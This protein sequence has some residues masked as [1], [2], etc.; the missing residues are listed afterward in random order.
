MATAAI[1]VSDGL[2]A[3]VAHLC[4]ASKVAARLDAASVP[5]SPAA[6]A[7]IDAE[8]ALIETALTGGDDYELAF[9]L[10]P[11]RRAAAS[12]LPTPVSLIG[13]IEAGE[14]V[15]VHGPAGE[16][17]TFARDGWRHF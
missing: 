6:R 11:G 9:T 7:R 3:D 16:E 2:V 15:A 1:D 12:S 4:R 14:G 17:L 13:S 8:P 10:P 5:L